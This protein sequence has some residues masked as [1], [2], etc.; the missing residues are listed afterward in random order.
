MDPIA[1]FVSSAASTFL[2]E[3]IAQGLGVA[4]DMIFGSGDGVDDGNSGSGSW[5]NSGDGVDGRL[6]GQ[7][8]Q[9]MLDRGERPSWMPEQQFNMM[10]LQRAEDMRKMQIELMTNLLKQDADLLEKIVNNIG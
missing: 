6:L 2:P 4:A 9:A 10:M 8:A 3:P 5:R 7:E 1:N